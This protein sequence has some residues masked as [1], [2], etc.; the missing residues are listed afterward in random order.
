MHCHYQYS[1]LMC[2][3][4]PTDNKKG[5]GLYKAKRVDLESDFW[6]RLYKHQ[7]VSLYISMII[8]LIFLCSELYSIL[9]ALPGVERLYAVRRH[10]LSTVRRSV[11]CGQTGYR[12]VS[13]TICSY[14]VPCKVL[15]SQCHVAFQRS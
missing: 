7:T 5:A 2:N 1:I 15:H 4:S 3:P 12:V 8:P 13:Q 6:H 10:A 9:I 14:T 11:V